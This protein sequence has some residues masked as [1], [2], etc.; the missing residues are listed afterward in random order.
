MSLT[1]RSVFG[2]FALVGFAA[3]LPA[4]ARGQ[5]SRASSSLDPYGEMRWGRSFEGQRKADIGDGTFLYAAGDGE[6]RF[7]NF[8]Y[9]A[10]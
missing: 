8:T 10:L 6:A 9:Q 3:M 1:R 4:P 2:N 7:S 5:G